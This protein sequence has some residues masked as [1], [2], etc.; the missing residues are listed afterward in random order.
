MKKYILF[1]LLPFL[2]LAACQKD[3]EAVPQPEFYQLTL[4]WFFTPH[5]ETAFQVI[6]DGTVVTDSLLFNQGQNFASKLIPGPS[7]GLKHLVLKVTGTDSTVLDTSVMVNGKTSYQLLAI[8]PDEKPRIYQGAGSGTEADPSQPSAGKIRY[9]YYDTQLPEEVKMVFYRV[10]LGVRPIAAE[11]TPFGE[12]RLKRGEFSPYLELP[13]TVYGRNTTY[14]F[15]LIDPSNDA[16]IQDI[17]IFPTPF[18]RTKGYSES[19]YA[20]RPP[21]A[22]GLPLYKFITS[23]LKM[24]GP[25]DPVP[26]RDKYH[27]QPLFQTTW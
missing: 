4:S 16:I 10:N 25:E 21:T 3:G 7:Q 6:V 26:R 22:D 23:I 1:L 8:S 15:K 9:Y 19:I 2:C 20:N 11:E 14:L 5:A 18:T 27:D 12:L 17:V 24:G 13:M